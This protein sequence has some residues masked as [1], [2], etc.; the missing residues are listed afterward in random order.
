MVLK[1]TELGLG[2]CPH[3]FAHTTFIPT[4]KENIFICDNCE[5]KLDNM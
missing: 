2:K 3:C 4:K 1:I 5:D